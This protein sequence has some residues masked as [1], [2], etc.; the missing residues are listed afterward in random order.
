MLK[1]EYCQFKKVNIYI[2]VFLHT[3]T[4]RGYLSIIA[5]DY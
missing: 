2:C 3:S 1:H 4:P 5:R